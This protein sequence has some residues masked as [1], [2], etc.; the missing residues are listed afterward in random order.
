VGLEG[1]IVD[2]IGQEKRGIGDYSLADVIIGDDPAKQLSVRGDFATD[3]AENDHVYVV[4]YITGTS[5]PRLGAS[6]RKYAGNVPSLSARALL[7][8]SEA[9]NLLKGS[10]TN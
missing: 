1:K 5:H 7:K 4:G 8:P 3:I 10:S 2:I 6:S 9:T